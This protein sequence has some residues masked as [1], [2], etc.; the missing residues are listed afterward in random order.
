M[1]KKL[2]E[3]LD[4]G[5]VPENSKEFY[6][7]WIS[8]LETNYMNLFKS[9]EYVDS[10]RKTLDSIGEF[11]IARKQMLEDALQTIPVPTQKEMDE[12]YKEIYLLKKKIKQLE[13]RIPRC[14]NLKN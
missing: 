9:P 1:Q 2:S 5:I 6:R 8:I 4:K 7:L 10:L 11:M 13:N 3:M 14:E 12:L